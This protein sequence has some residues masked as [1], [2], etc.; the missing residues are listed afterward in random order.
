ME[1]TPGPQIC[2]PKLQYYSPN[3]S[4]MS[5]GLCWSKISSLDPI[6][7]HVLICQKKST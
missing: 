7:V 6:K 4:G 5:S 2:V 1:E 3:V